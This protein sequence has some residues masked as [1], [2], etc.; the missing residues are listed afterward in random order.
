[1]KKKFLSTVR[2][3]VALLF[4]LFATN[5]VPI[6]TVS[7]NHGGSHAGG[8]PVVDTGG[9][10]GGN[11]VCPA[12]TTQIAKYNYQGGVYV[13][14]SGGASVTIGAGSTATSGTY[15][16]VAA[17]TSI[18]YV[19]VKGSDNAKTV[20]ASTSTGQS[21]TFD[22]SGLVNNGGQTSAISNIK[23]CGN[24]VTPP[25]DECPNIADTQGTVPAG[26][27]KDNQGNCVTPPND[28][29]PNIEGTQESVP[30]GMVKDNQ[31]NCVT[32]PTDE[33]PNIAGVQTLPLPTGI[34]KQNDNTCK[35]VICHADS[36]V[37]KPYVRQ[38]VAYD[39]VDGDAGNDNGQGDHYL[40]HDGPVF[41]SSMQQGDEWGDIIPPTPAQPTGLNWSTEGQAIYNNDCAP[42][43]PPVDECPNLEESTLPTGY[44]IDEQGNCV[45]PP[46]DVCPNIEGVQTQVPEGQFQAPDGTCFTPGRG[47]G[48]TVMQLVTVAKPVAPAPQV[49]GLGAEELVDTGSNVLLSIFVGMTIFGLTAGLAIATPRR[50]YS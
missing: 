30:A 26:M 11:E 19:I 40:E 17:N 28:E 27:V 29:C 5:I 46:T 10:G 50:R 39:S 23:F 45:L 22:N 2:A 43:T 48:E 37:K 9:A 38:S 7:A 15:T 1:M 12:G 14:E 13:A 24:T 49:G 42:T 41:N 20:A 16:V 3:S 4:M 34:V 18:T 33:C 25:T 6:A 8:P 31:G 47:G 35:V 44:V 36:A 32:P 21:G